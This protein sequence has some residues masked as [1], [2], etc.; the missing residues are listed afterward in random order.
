MDALVTLRYRGA[1]FE[2]REVAADRAG[3]T[4]GQEITEQELWAYTKANKEAF[5]EELNALEAAGVD[6]SVYFFY[7]EPAVDDLAA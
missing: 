2:A 4:H 5:I 7:L 6:T 1:P 3:L